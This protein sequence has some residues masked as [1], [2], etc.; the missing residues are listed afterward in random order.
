MRLDAVDWKRKKPPGEAFAVCG[1]AGVHS[2]RKL[3]VQGA[4]VVRDEDGIFSSA[5]SSSSS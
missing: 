1:V 4:R 5:F 3:D 2:A